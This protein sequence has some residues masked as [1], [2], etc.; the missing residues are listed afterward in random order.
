MQTAEFVQ[1]YS[2]ERHGTE[3]LKW[4]AL[5]EKY[6]DPDLIS[7]WVADMEFKTC[8]QITD[9]IKKRCD[10]GVFGY[11]Q[12]PGGYY[13]AFSNWMERHYGWT[14]Q[15][16][17]VRFSPGVVSALYWLVNAFTKPGDSCI[18]LTPVY[19]PFHNAIRESGRKLVMVDMINTQGHFTIDYEAFE[20]AIV[21]HQVK[22]FI[23]CSPHNPAGRVWTEEELDKVMGICKQ[24]G[25]LIISDEIHQ[26][27]N[28]GVHKQIPAALVRGGAYLDGLIAVSAASKTFNLAGLCHSNIVIEDKT[29][30]SIYDAYVQTIHVGG[31]N[32]LGQ[33]AA[34]TGY[35]Y[36]EE[37]L[38]SVLAV[39][40][41]NYEYLKNG[42]A[43]AAPKIVVTPLEGTYLAFL[44]L[45][46]YIKPEE[47]K[48]FI[49]D[50]C[51]L[52]VDFGE[53]FGENF[54]GFVRL[55]LATDPKY[56]KQAVANIGREV[57]KL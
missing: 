18:V 51:R 53:W 16:D 4:D 45:R 10:H 11:S 54:K 48:E 33:L 56:V 35:L 20:K 40:K 13:E 27:L 31:S 17:W 39:I 21:D 57:A 9:A 47:T 38:D 36:G 3:S 26:D 14:V 34:M 25:V 2:V 22:L 24:H 1:K 50:K 29:L 19:Y 6:G 46:G 41:E 44:D 15:K 43:Q 8:E 52:A 55:N 12:V 42:L 28:L 5:E 37:W 23:Q 32:Y 30:R 7:M 49:Q